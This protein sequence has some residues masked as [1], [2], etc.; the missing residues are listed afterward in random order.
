MHQNLVLKIEIYQML[1]TNPAFSDENSKKKY[2]ICYSNKKI[3]CTETFDVK[4]MNLIC[5]L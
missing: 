2:S 4:Y 1:L 3:P 5:K